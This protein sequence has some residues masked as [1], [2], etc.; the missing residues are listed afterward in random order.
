MSN[1]ERATEVARAFV[2]AFNARDARAMADSF[3]FPHVR[4]ALGRFVTIESAEAMI[5]RQAAVDR[6]L[7]AEGWD[8]TRVES[9]EV[10]HEGP[11]KV[12]LALRHSRCRPDGSAYNTFDTLWIVTEH[13]G[14]WGIQFR[15]SY[16]R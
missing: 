7:Q 13:D 16:L 5:A 15:S 2:A 14:R 9:I 4:L 11:D 12:H 8:H 10:V 3:H 6:S 1:A